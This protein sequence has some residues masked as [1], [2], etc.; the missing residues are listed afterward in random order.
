MHIYEAQWIYKFIKE[1]VQDANKIL[2]EQG[3]EYYTSYKD[4]KEQI[5]PER[6][7]GR[8]DI[9]YDLY[10]Q[11]EDDFD[12]PGII[13][14]PESADEQAMAKL[15]E[16]RNIH[17]DSEPQQPSNL[18]QENPEEITQEDIPF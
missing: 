14:Y 11:L 16:L 6:L 9:V 2:K 17:D 10:G 3:I 18:S 5:T 7:K 1:T 4:G 8:L 15:N 12:Y 13:D